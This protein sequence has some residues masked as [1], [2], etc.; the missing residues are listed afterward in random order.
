MVEH[1]KQLARKNIA[2]YCNKLEDRRFMQTYG[3][4][5]LITTKKLIL[6]FDTILPAFWV[7]AL[8]LPDRYNKE[9]L[10]IGR[11]EKDAE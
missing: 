9:W 8:L 11:R 4:V 6:L 1:R 3:K 7:I 5:W 10:R 2:K